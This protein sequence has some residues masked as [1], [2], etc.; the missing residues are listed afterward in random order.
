MSAAQPPQIAPQHAAESACAVIPARLGSTRFPG[1]MLAAATG[2][3][4]VQH[5]WERVRQARHID[6]IIIATDDLRIAEAVAAFGGDAVMTRQDHVSGTTRIAEVAEGLD[7][8]LL[9]NVQGDEPEVEPAIIDRLVELLEER[10]ECPMATLATPLD[11]VEDLVN[12]NVVKLVR[13]LDG[14][15]L[16]FSR[17]PIP[18]DREGAG[19]APPLRHLGLYGYRREFLFRYAALAE[20]PLER[21]ERLEQLRALEHGVPI[22]VA[23]VHAS[24]H[25]IDTPE[26]YAAFVARCGAR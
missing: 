19:E 17:S 18:F 13:R 3:P 11:A 21:T 22:A 2:K 24:G 23:I 15:A 25:G 1:K 4:L 20:S 6:R 8:P 12:P 9:I 16:Y 10:P 14:T 26:Q 5:V 7:V